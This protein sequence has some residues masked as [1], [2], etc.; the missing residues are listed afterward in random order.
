LQVLLS[1]NAGKG[2]DSD[3]QVK[4][5]IRIGSVEVSTEGHLS[6]LSKEVPALY[7]FFSNFQ[8]ITSPEIGSSREEVE[9]LSS[10]ETPAIKASNSTTDNIRSLFDTPWGRTPRTISEIA[11]ALEA[12]AVPDATPKIGTYLSRLVKRGNLRRI[13]REEGWSYYRIPVA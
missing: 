13:Q 8:G 4:L 5:T 10:V 6:E 7:Q 11:K 1:K 9:S 3:L 2:I 12:N